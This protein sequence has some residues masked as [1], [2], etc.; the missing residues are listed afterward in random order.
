MQSRHFEVTISH[1]HSLVIPE[2]I[3]EDF[4]EAGH[5]R[6][7]VLAHFQNNSVEFHAAVQKDQIGRYRIT[8]GR[9][10]QREL[11]V[12]TNDYFSLQFLEDQTK[13]GVEIPEEME[14]VLF[15]D[16]VALEAFESL[17]AG[18]KRSLIYAVKKYKNSQTRIDKS[19]LL[20]ENL[21]RGI[22]DLKLLF[23]T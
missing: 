1:G 21:K 12:F 18:R 6:V 4:L 7:K 15:S 17:T 10:L 23:K 19:L 2:D 13:Y 5:T 8:F 9:S 14:A 22:T 3:A 16:P 11:G 20:C